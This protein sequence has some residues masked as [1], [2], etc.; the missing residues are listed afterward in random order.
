LV[1]ELIEYELPRLAVAGQAATSIGSPAEVVVQ[2]LSEPLPKEL[3]EA[4]THVV[5]QG[6]RNVRQAPRASERCGDRLVGPSPGPSLGCQL[7][8]PFDE[9]VREARQFETV[10]LEPMQ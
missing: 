10:L 2:K 7:G 1:L 6:Q 4:R 3:G 5:D 9:N 8:D